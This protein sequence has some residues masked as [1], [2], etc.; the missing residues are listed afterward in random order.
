MAVKDTAKTQDLE[1]PSPVS[2]G[3][4]MTQ[5]FTYFKILSRK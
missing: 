5:S 3:S 1:L 4:K 2:W